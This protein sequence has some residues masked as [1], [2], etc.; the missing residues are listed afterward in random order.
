MWNAMSFEE[1]RL[2]ASTLSIIN[3]DLC[4][5]LKINKDY[6][7]IPQWLN[8]SLVIGS[9]VNLFLFEKMLDNKYVGLFSS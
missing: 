2:D 7:L 1:E 6:L 8:N 3:F 9:L 5:L 4:F